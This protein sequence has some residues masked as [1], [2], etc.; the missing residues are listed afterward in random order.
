LRRRRLRGP[1]RA[2]TVASGSLRPRPSRGLIVN[3]VDVVDGSTTA[4]GTVEIPVGTK[5]MCDCRTR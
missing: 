2:A 1:H 4:C 5:S 3:D